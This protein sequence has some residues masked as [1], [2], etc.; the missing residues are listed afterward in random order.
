MIEQLETSASKMIDFKL[1]GKLY[2]QNY[3]TFVSAIGASLAEEGKVC[4]FVQS[5]DFHGWDLHA[6]WDDINFAAK[7]RLELKRI[8]IVSERKREEWIANLCAPF[9]RLMHESS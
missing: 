7:H 3:K 1:S 8:A 6:A 4:L 5:E 2:D 9:T